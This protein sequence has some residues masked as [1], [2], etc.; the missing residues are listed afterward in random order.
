MSGL[1]HILC[2]KACVWPGEY[3]CSVPRSLNPPLPSRNC[4]VYLFRL[5]SHLAFFIFLFLFMFRIETRTMQ[6]RLYIGRL[7]DKV[8]ERD[9]QDFFR[10]YGKV[11][12]IIMKNGYGFVVSVLWK[13]LKNTYL[14]LSSAKKSPILKYFLII[15]FYR[16]KIKDL[17]STKFLQT[18]IFISSSVYNYVTK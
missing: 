17:F 6:N 10:G 14:R 3:C 1:Q 13:Y 12:D 18:R 2:S 9:V 5:N 11:K 8:R 4:S 16:I 15:F 7:S